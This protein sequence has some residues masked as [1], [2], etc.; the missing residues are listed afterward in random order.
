MRPSRPNI[1]NN[2]IL[3]R[4]FLGRN[5]FKRNYLSNK[6]I[7]INS[8]KK[9]EISSGNN[10]DIHIKKL[11]FEPSPESIS[12][13]LEKFKKFKAKR[14][15]SSFDQ[16]KK[17][18]NLFIFRLQKNNSQKSINYD[19]LPKLS[20]NENSSGKIKNSKSYTYNMKNKVRQ[21]FVYNPNFPFIKKINIVDNKK[22]K[23]IKINDNNFHS[24]LKKRN[25]INIIKVSKNSGYQSIYFSFNLE[26]QKESSFFEKFTNNLNNSERALINMDNRELKPQRPK[27]IRNMNFNFVKGFYRFKND[28]K[29]NYT[30]INEA[31]TN[32]KN[33]QN[34]DTDLMLNDKGTLINFN[35]FQNK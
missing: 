25:P 11:I 8:E 12:F 14:I 4:H 32:I 34:L 29:S 9:S 22:P 31:K 7:K 19:K 10:N 6:N 27:N 5:Q 23:R 3:K 17:I 28:F 13:D 26:K 2:N 35:D 16:L 21:N 24:L 33:E 30:K 1:I 15:N 20:F 18:N